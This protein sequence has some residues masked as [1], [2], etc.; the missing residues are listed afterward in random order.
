FLLA[1]P[2]PAAA[3]AMVHGFLDGPEYLARPVTLASHVTLLYDRRRRRAPAAAGLVD[4]VGRL[5]AQYDT[6]LPGFVASPEFQRLV[7]DVHDRPR[8]GAAVD[9]LQHEELPHS[10]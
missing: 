7:P 6:A 10:A 3:S 2:T 5:Q 4:W 1:N 8:G 9:R